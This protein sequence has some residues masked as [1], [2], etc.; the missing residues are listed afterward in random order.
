M[1]YLRYFKENDSL[2]VNDGIL[3]IVD[4]QEEF[5]KHIPDDF[6]PK[7]N[8]YCDEFDSVYQ[9]WDSNK[10]N[11]PTYKFKKQ[12]E[13]IE[14]KYGIKKNYKDLD[15]GILEYFTQLFGEEDANIILNKFN[16]KQLKE[17]KDKFK[18]KD[19][20]EYLVFT[21][22][23]HNWFYVN[24]KLVKLFNE[25]KG[26]KIIIVGGAGEECVKDIYVSSESFGL[27]PMY[28]YEYVYDAT[29]RN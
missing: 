27:Y 1:K 24:E 16:K 26:K 23:N 11:K 19:K 29:Y 21:N 12:V 22:N 2:D 7:L 13:S 28:N 18:V 10:T 14:K 15:G 4:V 17:G 5:E 3:F 6:V 20:N 8:K 9:I 25:L